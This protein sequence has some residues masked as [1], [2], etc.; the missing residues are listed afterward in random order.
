MKEKGS[1][2]VLDYTEDYSAEMA[3]TSPNDTIST[4][5]WEV[6]G[7]LRIGNLASPETTDS[8]TTTTTTVWLNGGRDYSY[9][10][11]INTIT[12]AAGRTY[13]RRTVF[14]IKPIECS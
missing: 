13:V 11:A 3:A 5:T 6:T 1:N 4:S 8:K 9:A 10:L 7:G 12:T 2:E 14:D